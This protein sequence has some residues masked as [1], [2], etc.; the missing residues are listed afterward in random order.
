MSDLGETCYDHVSGDAYC[1]STAAE[2]W[3]KNMFNRLKEKYP[4]DIT[5]VS[6]N[7]DGSMV[8][9]FPYA[10]LPRVRPKRKRHLTE[11][12]KK[13]VSDR[14]AAGTVKPNQNTL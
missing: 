10:W 2:S 4:D 6:K 12:Q 3:S 9:R 8:V 14:L 7:E 5:I 11:E 13:A 1:T